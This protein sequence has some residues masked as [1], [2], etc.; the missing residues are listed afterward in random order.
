MA[1][2]TVTFSQLQ[3]AVK[4]VHTGV[5]AAAGAISRSVTISASGVLNMVRV[6]N[7]STLLDFWLKVHTGGA[8]QTV[9]IGTSQTPSG[10]M[11]VTTLSQTY[12]ISGQVAAP[13]AYGDNNTG[14]IR[15]PGGTKGGA[16]DLMPVRISLSDDVQPSSVWVQ[17]RLGAA[18]SA[19]AFF[20]FCLFYTMDGLRGH[21]TIR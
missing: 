11:S 15:A 19:S 18:I 12:S 3:D 7:H 14:V 1:S 8:S 2:V 5:I 9:Q 17:G 20:T 10:I 13:T 16:I 4:S 6:P 21:T